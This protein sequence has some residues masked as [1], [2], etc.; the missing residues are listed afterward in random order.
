MVRRCFPV[1]VFTPH[2]G[3]LWIMAKIVGSSPI[4]VELFCHFGILFFDFAEVERGQ[5]WDYLKSRSSSNN[6]NNDFLLK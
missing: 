4:S 3:A 5:V 2:R 6:N 1:R